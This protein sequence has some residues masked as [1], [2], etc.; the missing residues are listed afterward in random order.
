MREML[1][2]HRREIFIALLFVIAL[3]NWPIETLVV[4]T[5]RL[6]ITTI[7]RHR[8]NTNGAKDV[9]DTTRLR[10]M[11]R[12]PLIRFALSLFGKK[13]EKVKKNGVKIRR[14]VWTKAARECLVYVPTEEGTEITLAIVWAILGFFSLNWGSSMDADLW[15]VMFMAA[16]LVALIKIKLVKNSSNGRLW[17]I[18]LLTLPALWGAWV[19]DGIC[20]ILGAVLLASNKYERNDNIRTQREQLG[21]G[22]IVLA[23]VV[24]GAS[25]LSFIHVHNPRDAKARANAPTAAAP[26]PNVSVTINGKTFSVPELPPSDRVPMYDPNAEALDYARPVPPSSAGYT[27]CLTMLGI[28]ETPH[29]PA[30]LAIN[31]E[32][33]STSPIQQDAL[34]YSPGFTMDM[35][36]VRA[37]KGVVICR[38]NGAGG[39][40]LALDDQLEKEPLVKMD[41]TR[42]HGATTGGLLF[43]VLR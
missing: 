8:P 5:A 14:K 19:V 42:T 4:V 17:C 24:F 43:Y 23:A 3:I 21:I 27:A 22:V 25:L 38:D 9:R 26:V 37:P 16:V 18:A 10:R 30:L 40:E 1:Q 15:V 28:E 13:V 35:P 32:G 41:S 39:S 20:V 29:D 31:D 11:F 36:I 2:K 6:T 12:K 7:D 34:K 33:R